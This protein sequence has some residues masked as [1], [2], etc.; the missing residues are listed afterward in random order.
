MTA[1]SPSQDDGAN[2]SEI[3]R[4]LI[5]ISI[6]VLNEEDNIGPLLDRLRAITEINNRYDFEFIF[7]DNASDDRTFEIL[8]TEAV[9]DNRIRVIRFTQNFGFQR[10]I[11]TNYLNSKGEAAIQIDADL[12]DPPEMISE[13]LSAWERGYK[14]VY[15]VRRTRQESSLLSGLRRLFYRALNR[16]SNVDIPVDAGDF[17]LIDRIVIENLREMRDNS[18][19]IRGA[20]AELGY[21]QI[22][23]P[24]D[25]DRRANGASKFKILSLIRLGMD[26]ICSHSTKPLEII[27][28]FGFILSFISFI[29]IIFYLLWFVVISDDQTPG[30]TTIVILIL[31][32]MGMNAAFIGILGE[33][34][35][36]IFRNT[37]HIPAPII[38]HRIEP[39]R[40]LAASLTSVR[41]NLSRPKAD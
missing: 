5:S 31:L 6:P 9:K 7:T 16:L 22:G 35:G 14:V 20:I 12:Q 2:K 8:S 37:R 28:L 4:R 15:G 13:F 39:I 17:R 36:R 33:Y 26:G 21:P 41:E 32:S 3:R 19:Y 40:Q 27:T 1:A 18:P 24:Y 10:S 23:I 11:L 30:F 38:E 29:S 25:R 34:I